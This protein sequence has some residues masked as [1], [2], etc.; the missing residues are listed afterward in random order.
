MNYHFL[1]AEVLSR[2]AVPVGV[3]A[4][5]HLLVAY[6][7][8]TALMPPAAPPEVPV[9]T[10]RFVTEVVDPPPQPPPDIRIPERHGPIEAPHI[11]PLTSPPDPH[12]N[13]IQAE[14]V[15]H[16]GSGTAAV[17]PPLPIRLV[18]SNVLPNS[19]NFY[20]PSLIREGVQGATSLRVCVDAQG[21]RQGEATLEQTSGNALLDRAALEMA[22]R[23]RYARAMQGD[24]A[25]GNCYRFRITFQIPK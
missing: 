2:R 12:R 1:Q 10:G 13:A 18:G 14:P 5:F 7:L 21:V 9:M 16:P 6:L 8:L 11:D 19:A 25:V 22:R 20:P 3:I 23:G 17:A 24:T 15:E 4:A